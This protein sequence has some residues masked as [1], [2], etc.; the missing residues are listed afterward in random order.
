MKNII[1]IPWF[2]PAQ[3]TKW[4]TDQLGYVEGCLHIR[5][6]GL[7]VFGSVYQTFPIF[8]TTTYYLM[9]QNVNDTS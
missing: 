5:L 9:M 4:H 3:Q 6:G 1:Q 2:T 8:M 7:G